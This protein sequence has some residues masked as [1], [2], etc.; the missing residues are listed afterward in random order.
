MVRVKP[1]VHDKVEVGIVSEILDVV[2]FRV[3]KLGV[4]ITRGSALLEM[5]VV[6]IVANPTACLKSATA[7]G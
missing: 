5:P 3:T 7:A 6:S 1:L 4:I 2:P